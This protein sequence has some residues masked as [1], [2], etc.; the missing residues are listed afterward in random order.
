MKILFISKFFLPH[1]GGI[2]NHLQE[3]SK[4]LIKQEHKV[5]IITKRLSNH[6][7]DENLGKIEILRISYPMIKFIGLIVIWLQLLRYIKFIKKVD[8][9][10]I[11]DVFV[12]CIPLKI[13]F[14]KKPLFLTF[15]GYESY[16]IKKRAFW[17]RKLANRC[18]KGNLCVGHFMEKWYKTITP[19]FIYGAVNK[20][21][22]Y[23]ENASKNLYKYDAIF[24]SR[25]DEQT[26]I[27]TYLKSTQILRR[28]NIKFKLAVLGDGIY[29]KQADKVATTFGFVKDPAPYFKVS[30]FAFVS[31]YLA[32]LEAMACKKLVFATYDNPLKEDYLRMT[33]FAKWII[34]EKDPRKLAD[35]VEYYMKHPGEEKKLIEPAY[36]WARQQTWE[37]VADVYLKLWRQGGVNI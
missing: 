23:R 26:G 14:P 33:P 19:F 11:H 30:R 29:R 27:I 1:V 28:R 20:K 15:H 18:T 32:I 5:S 36:R 16:P 25:L 6:Q 4:I 12:W 24:S 8:I 7:P 13:L 21:V 17:I 10:H 37:K 34:I 9:V 2:E 31:R 35:R 3:I 22:F